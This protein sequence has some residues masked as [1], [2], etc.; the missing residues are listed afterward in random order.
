MLTIATLLFLMT[1]CHL[2]LL[3]LVLEILAFLTII[4]LS[5]RLDNEPIKVK[6]AF[7][8]LVINGVLSVP[9]LVGTV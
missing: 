5:L 2:I 9:M 4:L 8:Y 3:I 6:F 7:L 1:I